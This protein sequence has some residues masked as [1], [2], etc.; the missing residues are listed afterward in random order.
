MFSP[1]KGSRTNL[2]FVKLAWASATPIILFPRIMNSLHDHTLHITY[3]S[4]ITII[5]LGEINENNALKCPIRLVWSQL[6]CLTR[7]RIVQQMLCGTRDRALL[8]VI[9]LILDMWRYVL[10]INILFVFF[11]SRS[12]GD[13]WKLWKYLLIHCNC[14]KLKS[15]IAK[16]NK[17]CCMYEIFANIMSGPGLQKFYTAE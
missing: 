4:H 14:M 16:Q 3:T 6:C 17:F 7:W 11:I 8:L 5:I 2:Q 13:S 10:E 1:V 15:T 12:M 9:L